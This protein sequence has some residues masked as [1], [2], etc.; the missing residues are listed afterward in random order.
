MSHYDYSLSTDFEDGL[1]NSQLINEINDSPSIGPNC[2]NVSTEDDIVSIWFTTL[3]SGAEET[4]LDDI[5]ADHT[6]I[7][8]ET[9]IEGD[10]FIMNGL[11]DKYTCYTLQN[12][13]VSSGSD[14]L[15]SGSWSHVIGDM[16]G[17]DGN[18]TYVIEQSG[19]YVFSISVNIDATVLNTLCQFMVK[20]ESGVIT[21]SVHTVLPISTS[22]FTL[23]L[24]G[25]GVFS[26]SS[27]LRL[28]A[29]FPTSLN[30][31]DITFKIC[32]IFS[33]NI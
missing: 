32:R 7:P 14:V 25:G 2:Y 30:V 6:P 8:E 19:I 23:F 29:R 15:L 18:G 5:V 22:N 33:G 13:S 1:D 10:N 16:S 24:G 26:E 3:L 31:C 12:K 27:E 20:N 11:T 17:F 21:N 28:Y 4:A 9:I